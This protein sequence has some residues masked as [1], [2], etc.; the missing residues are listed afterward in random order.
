M[1][2][3]I[4]TSKKFSST[5]YENAWVFVDEKKIDENSYIF[6]EKFYENSYIFVEKFYE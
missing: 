6:V 3:Y 5:V 2:I 1:S 4:K